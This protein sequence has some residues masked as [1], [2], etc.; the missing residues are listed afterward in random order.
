MKTGVI[1]WGETEGKDDRV[2]VYMLKHVMVCS[3]FLFP[4]DGSGA[5][6]L[7]KHANKAASAPRGY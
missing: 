7:W 3:A 5:P 1:E 2:T 4:Q 6:L